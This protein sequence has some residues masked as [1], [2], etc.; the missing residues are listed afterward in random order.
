MKRWA[1]YPWRRSGV[2]ARTGWLLAGAYGVAELLIVV[3]KFWG[4]HGPYGMR[5]INAVVIAACLTVTAVCAGIA[6]RGK[7]GRQRYGWLAL[8]TGLAGWAAGE[9]IWAVYDVRPEFDHAANP[10]ATEIVLLLYPIGAMASLVLLSRLSRLDNFRRLLLDGLIV[11]TSLFVI[12]W[13]FVVETQLREHTGTSLTTLVEVFSDIVLLTTAI[14]MLSRARPGDQ[15]SRI[16][17]AS[18]IGTINLADLVLVFDT[19]IG[20]YHTGYLADLT[21][22]AGLAMLALAA[23]ASRHERPPAPLSPSP[24]EVELHTRL[25]LPYL[26]LTM[27]AAVGWAHAAGNTLHKPLLGAL[28]ILVAA[29][30]ARQFVAL[31]ENQNLLSEVAQEAFRDHLTGLANRALFLHR[32]ELAVAR[33]HPDGTP[34]AVLCLDLDNFKA[35]NDA[36]GHPAG[37]ELLVRVAGRLTAA[38]GDTG[39]IARLGGDEFA[40]VIEASVEES[41]AAAHRILDAFAGAILIDGIPITVR[42]SIGFTVAT[43]SAN[44]TVDQLLRHADLAM[45]AAKREGGQCIRSFMPDLP[46]PYAFPAAPG[47]NKSPGA[48]RA[49]S[50]ADGDAPRDRRPTTEVA[51]A[52]PSPP[53]EA[54]DTV[55]W[56]PR[57]V[58]TAIVL[59][60]IGVIAFTVSSVVRPNAGHGIVSAAALFTALTVVAA[61]LIALRAYRVPAD[62][63]AWALIAAGMASSAVGD[64]VYALWVPNGRS[65]SVA[66]PEYL[67]YY[68]FVYAGLLLL[69]R[70]RLKRL[71]MPIQLDSFICA[72]TLAAVA[73][74]LTAGPIRAAAVR[75]PATVWVGLAYPWS[76]LVLLAL[77]AGMLP[78]LGWRNE[79][80]WALL[81]AGLVLFAVSDAAY[82]FQSSAGVYRAGSLLDAGWAA[83][84]LLIAM[85]SW[86]RS[87]SI[88]PPSRGRCGPYITPVVAAIVAL[89]VIVLAYHSRLAAT[90]AALSLVVATG[91]FALTFRNAGLLQTND[92]HAM[93]DELTALPNRRSLATALSGLPVSPPTGSRSMPTRARAR[94]ALLLLSLSDFHEITDSIGSQFGDELLCHI[95]NRLT[96]CVRRD[97]LLARVGED[98]FA[99]LL[100]DGANLTAASASAGRLLEALS[101]PIALDP[102]TVQVDARIAIAL[103]PDHCDSPQDLLSRA[104]ITMAHAKSAR[105]KIAVYDS[106]LEVHRDNDPS[107]IE[108]LRTALF[109]TD[110]LRLHYQPKIDGR[111]GSVHSVEAVLRWQHPTRGT[112]LPEE[113]LSVAERAGLMRKISNRTLSM[114]LAQVRSWRDEGMPLTV[115]VNLSTT[116]LLDIELVGTVERLLANHDLPAEALILE[117][118][119][120]A[121]VDSVRS[122]NTVA[123]LQGLGIRISLD[124]YGTG[125]SSLARLQEVSVDEL[126]LDRIFVS[127]LAHDARS[128]AIVRSTVALASNL[129]AD[130]VAEGV[131]NEATLNALR[132]YGCN[133]TQ[134]FVHSP[135]L[136]P[137]DLRDWIAGNAPNSHPARSNERASSNEG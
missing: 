124:D 58:R 43:G 18:G 96:G 55:R 127:R 3:S 128:V 27:A 126:K 19:G 132:R 34:I 85:A 68:P 31:V 17:L 134:G 37:D 75:S 121:L 50:G 69:M 56:P 80:R 32:L 76:D 20:S 9:I 87:S 111:D 112:L 28:G 72:L 73:A 46:L 98:Q 130:L 14:L 60:T 131:E 79:I 13:V 35:V 25:W 107:L 65:P 136:P 45:Y 16:L 78:I 135:P 44:C 108:E 115:A 95:A 47:S 88:T 114:A 36:L 70:A 38:L 61:G 133:I 22:V 83:S 89:G 119:E 97:D 74:A 24:D 12:S 84:S 103:C 54:P 23:A 40:A 15:P 66:D 67:A 125:W 122:R 91:R 64:V 26:P 102:I 77:A 59:L 33:R 6:A 71:P 21:R 113:F 101:E 129:G 106:S 8:V 120:S 52:A 86:A 41:Q 104:E 116:N 42:P 1:V 82:L 90:L 93:I 51:T 94:R 57:D 39:T 92:R 109:D 105:S 117:I 10:A 5:P 53:E 99:V 137:D 4:S 100:S 63:L 30:L 11:A 110:E 123:A 48:S 81:V 7:D 2:P 62:R 29:V 49:I 118:T